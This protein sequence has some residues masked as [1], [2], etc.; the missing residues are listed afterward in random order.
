MAKPWKLTKRY[1]DHFRTVATERYEYCADCG[2]TLSV[3]TSNDDI[4]LSEIVVAS[5]AHSDADLDR[6]DNEG[7]FD[8]DVTRPLAEQWPWNG[9]PVLTDAEAATIIAQSSD[10]YVPYAERIVD[11]IVDEWGDLSAQVNALDDV[12]LPRVERDIL[13]MERQSDAFAPVDTASREPWH[14]TQEKQLSDAC[15]AAVDAL[16]RAETKLRESVDAL[17]EFVTEVPEGAA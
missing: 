16:D 17:A 4:P 7:A 5:C 13:A 14:T 2:A 10:S 8:W 15:D 3:G 6:Y 12:E 11:R 9:E 1:C